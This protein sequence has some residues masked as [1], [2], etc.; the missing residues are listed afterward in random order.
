[1]F[2][3]IYNKL[4]FPLLERARLQK[5]GVLFLDYPFISEIQVMKKTAQENPH[6]HPFTALFKE[7][8]KEKNG[9]KMPACGGSCVMGK[10]MVAINSVD[11]LNEVYIKSNAY[12][13]K[14][15]DASLVLR[16]F[17]GENIVF[18]DT[19]HKDYALTRKVLSAAFF[20]SKL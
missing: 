18:M 6:A 3:L 8:A 5:Q 2:A 10:A 20:K 11:F 4:I 12:N 16:T 1:M 7:V 17:S 13:T 19:F 9:G 14:D 15:M